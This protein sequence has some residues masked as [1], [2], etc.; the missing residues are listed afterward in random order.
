MHIFNFYDEA[1]VLLCRRETRYTSV[2]RKSVGVICQRGGYGAEHERYQLGCDAIQR[3]YGRRASASIKLR[4]WTFEVVFVRHS[5]ALQSRC[6]NEEVYS[7]CGDNGRS[8]IR[9][10]SLLC[11]RKTSQIEFFSESQMLV[12]LSIG[13]KQPWVDQAVFKT[14]EYSFLPE[15][16]SPY[17]KAIVPNY[18]YQ[19]HRHNIIS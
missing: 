4:G 7:L 9:F 3:N 19:F 18:T 11:L 14:L 17:L 16:A 5:V 12:N 8:V 10:Y 1:T 13:V 15:Y 2:L 6:H